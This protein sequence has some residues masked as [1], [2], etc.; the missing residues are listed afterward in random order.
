[1]AYKTAT[2]FNFLL[3]LLHINNDLL[4]LSFFFLEVFIGN[5]IVYQNEVLAWEMPTLQN[6]LYHPSKLN[7]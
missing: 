6:L 4:S 1:M 3:S 5:Q 7:M 2:P